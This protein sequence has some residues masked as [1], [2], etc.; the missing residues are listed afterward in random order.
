MTMKTWSAAIQEVQNLDAKRNTQ[1][2]MF[3]VLWK[4][5]AVACQ[6]FWKKERWAYFEKKN[7]NLSDFKGRLTKWIVMQRKQTLFSDIISEYQDHTFA[8]ALPEKF[9]PGPVYY[10]SYARFVTWATETFKVDQADVANNLKPTVNDRIRLASIMGR[11]DNRD[12]VIKLGGAKNVSRADADGPL[13][14]FDSIF[15]EIQ[16]QFNDPELTLPE[17]ER[18]SFL[19]TYVHLDPNDPERIKITRDYKWIRKVWMDTISNYNKGLTK[20]KLNTG[21][22][23]GATEDFGDNINRGRDDEAFTKYG[24]WVGNRDDLAWVYMVDKSISFAFNTVNDP[25]PADSVMEDGPATSTASAQTKR[26]STKLSS[27]QPDDQVQICNTMA[28]GFDMI[29]KLFLPEGT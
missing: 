2:S 26:S 21:G 10:L 7:A 1:C 24:P 18:A 6:V 20:W 4:N 16:M 9:C 27:K 3:P 11:Q 15:L 22:G 19:S 17:P 25:A 28:N 13:S 23:P 29:S 12:H 14:M 5:V 8:A